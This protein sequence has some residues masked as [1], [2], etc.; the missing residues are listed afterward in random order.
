MLLHNVSEFTDPI[1][2]LEMR[3]VIFISD[4]FFLV[5]ELFVL[6]DSSFLDFFS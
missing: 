2:C 3:D 6:G 4:S 5:I 1:F